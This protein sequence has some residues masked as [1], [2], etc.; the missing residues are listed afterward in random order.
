MG[1]VQTRAKDNLNLV[2]QHLYVFDGDLAT[3]DKVAS[4]LKANWAKNKVASAELEKLF[5]GTSAESEYAEYV[6]LRDK[7]VDAQ[8]RAVALS[9]TETVDEV[10]ER[11]GSRTTLHGR[12]PQGRRRLQDRR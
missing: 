3:E 2:A 7:Y 4:Q 8:K 6:Q 12:A 5:A 1:G 11:D 9:R 10:E